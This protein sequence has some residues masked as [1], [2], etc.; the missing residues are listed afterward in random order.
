[1]NK[2]KLLKNAVI[3]YVLKFKSIDNLIKYFLAKYLIELKKK[4]YTTMFIIINLK[5]AIRLFR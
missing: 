2:Q 5:Y 4:T 3:L 1:M